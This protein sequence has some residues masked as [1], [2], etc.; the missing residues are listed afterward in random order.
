MNKVFLDDLPRKKEGGVQID[1]KNCIGASVKYVYKNIEGH[2]E[3][4]R[5]DSPNNMLDIKINNQIIKCATNQLR[6]C[7]FGYALGYKTTKYK[8]NIGDIFNNMLILEQKRVPHGENRHGNP[9]SEKGYKY[10]SLS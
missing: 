7:P 9:R 10:K 8:F 3:I 4:I 2:F 1:W 6:R 5:Y